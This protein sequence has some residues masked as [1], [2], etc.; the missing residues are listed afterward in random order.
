LV[1][2]QLDRDGHSRLVCM[3]VQQAACL[4]QD[5][6][7]PEEA[8]H[9]RAEWRGP[10]RG[11]C[12]SVPPGYGHTVT[13][14]N[15]QFV[16]IPAPPW[17]IGRAGA[18]PSARGMNRRGRL[19]G[20]RRR[21]AP[22][23]AACRRYLLPSVLATHAPGSHIDRPLVAASTVNVA[24]QRPVKIGQIGPVR[25]TYL[26][27]RAPARQWAGGAPS[28]GQFAHL[29]APRQTRE[30]DLVGLR[31]EQ[32]SRQPMICWPPQGPAPAL[33][34]SVSPAPVA[35]AAVVTG[36]MHPVIENRLLRRHAPGRSGDCRDFALPGP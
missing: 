34:T 26:N 13:A 32:A 19:A 27:W 6:L 20:R 7:P 30:H 15:R 33:P 14:G 31:I 24:P 18:C 8:A 35:L 21:L 29:R 36:H 11:C 28:A 4:A 23:M 9:D 5:Q 25:R 3:C 22:T 17:C 16:I 2:W 12:S 1:I 10:L